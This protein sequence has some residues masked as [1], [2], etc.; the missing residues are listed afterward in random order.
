MADIR[1]AD[2]RT[3]IKLETPAQIRQTLAAEI[4]D[5]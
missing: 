5:Q 1:T 2:I 4:R 3:S